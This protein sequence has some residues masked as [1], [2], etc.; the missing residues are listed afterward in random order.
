MRCGDVDII[1]CEEKGTPWGVHRKRGREEWGGRVYFVRAL[2]AA[3][4]MTARAADM[5][6]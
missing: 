4:K 5:F 3:P 6:P 2:L 1:P